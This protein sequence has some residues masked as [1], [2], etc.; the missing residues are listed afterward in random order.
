MVDDIP[1]L[2]LEA[3]SLPVSWSRRNLYVEVDQWDND[4]GLAESPV[5]SLLNDFWTENGH[6]ALQSQG[7]SREKLLRALDVAIT[8]HAARFIANSFQE[9]SQSLDFIDNSICSDVKTKAMVDHWRYLF[10]IWRSILPQISGD[11]DEALEGSFFT[12]ADKETQDLRVKYC[13]L[14]KNC[15]NLQ[16]RN[17]ETFQA[18]MSTL[19]IMESKAAIGQGHKIQKLTELAFVFIPLSF[20]AS[21]FGMEVKVRAL[22]PSHQLRIWLTHYIEQ[23][24]EHKQPTITFFFISGILII[25]SIYL[26]VS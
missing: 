18:V 17:A 20:T 16:T 26:L 23:D 7:S 15:A 8:T 21:F 3:T 2:H 24:F 6:T 22:N 5:T 11:I 12:S 19:S 13:K 4:R 14:L 9:I 10:G 1:H 25:L